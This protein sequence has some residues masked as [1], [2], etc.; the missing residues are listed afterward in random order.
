MCLRVLLDINIVSYRKEAKNSGLDGWSFRPRVC[1]WELSDLL[2]LAVLCQGMQGDKGSEA[3]LPGSVSP[4]PQESPAPPH[5]H[6]FHSSYWGLAEGRVNMALTLHKSTVQ[7]A[8]CG[9]SYPRQVAYM[10]EGSGSLLFMTPK[11]WRGL[12]PPGLS[13][14]WSLPSGP[15]LSHTSQPHSPGC[16]GLCG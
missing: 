8:N 10:C 2:G 15:R 14:S 12:S 11:Q 4:S 16:L 6:Q 13:G 5:I 1:I 9:I 7:D 3:G